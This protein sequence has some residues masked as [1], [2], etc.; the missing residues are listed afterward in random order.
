MV[1]RANSALVCKDVHGC[2][3][4]QAARASGTGASA[5][6]RYRPFILDSCAVFRRKPSVAG[7]ASAELE[8]SYYRE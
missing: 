6:A 3:S 5:A 2:S 1:D 4:D 8:V 7:Q